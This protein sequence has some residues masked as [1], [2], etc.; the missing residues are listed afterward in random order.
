MGKFDGELEG[1]ARENPYLREVKDNQIVYSAKTDDS[2]FGSLN[3]ITRKWGKSKLVMTT[4][5][6]T[7]GNSY[8]PPVPDFDNVFVYG[9]ST[10]IVADTFQTHMRVRK[11]KNNRMIFCLLS[12]KILKMNGGT[13]IQFKILQVYDEYTNE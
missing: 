5:C 11:L 4:P 13:N 6:I 9:M 12:Q 10:C 8:N 1:G 3:S 7:V 2:V